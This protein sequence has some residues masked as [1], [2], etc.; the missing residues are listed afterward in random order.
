MSCL[1]PRRAWS[2]EATFDLSGE[3]RRRTN[4]PTTSIEKNGGYVY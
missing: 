3:K 1:A 2:C 4:Q